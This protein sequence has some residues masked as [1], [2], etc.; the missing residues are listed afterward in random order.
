MLVLLCALICGFGFALALPPFDQGW[1]CWLALA[2]MLWA[3]CRGRLLEAAGVG[4]IAGLTCAV[5][6]VRWHHDTDRL[7]WAYLPFLWVSLLFL[8]VCAV[9]CVLRPRT[10]S[11]QWVI[12]V[13]ATRGRILS[14]LRRAQARMQP[15]ILLP[16]SY[17]NMRWE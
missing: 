16:V 9:A 12:G 3:A 4:M 2:P 10:G 13:V 8:I 6:Q 11:G 1:L 14:L 15:G 5:F 7:F 17:R